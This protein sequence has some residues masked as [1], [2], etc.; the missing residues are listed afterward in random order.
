MAEASEIKALLVAA[1][2]PTVGSPPPPAAADIWRAAAT[3][4]AGFEPACSVAGEGLP[5]MSR[6]LIPDTLCGWSIC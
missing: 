2:L 1:K 4:A 3:E 6:P 5:S